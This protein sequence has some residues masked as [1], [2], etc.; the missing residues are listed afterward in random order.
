MRTLEKNCNHNPNWK[1]CKGIFSLVIFMWVTFLFAFVYMIWVLVKQIAQEDNFSFCE[2]GLCLSFSCRCSAHQ[3]RIAGSIAF[4]PQNITNMQLCT[5]IWV[6]WLKAFWTWAC[7]FHSQIDI[8]CVPWATTSLAWAMEGFDVLFLFYIFLLCIFF[9]LACSSKA[10]AHMSFY[11]S[12]WR[13]KV[14]IMEAA[15]LQHGH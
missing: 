10:G 1:N 7:K 15:C 13:T 14:E 2:L 4:C 12:W 6:V 11:F 5:N 8:W 3:A 9:F